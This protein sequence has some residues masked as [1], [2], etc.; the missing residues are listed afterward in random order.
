[1]VCMPLD[2]ASAIPLLP[3]LVLLLAVAVPGVLL[4]RSL[5][6]PSLAGFLV[7]GMLLGPYGFGGVAN[8]EQVSTLA[9]LGVVLLL[10][11]IGLE[12]SVP[13]L[14]AMRR[15]LTIGGLGQV[16]GTIAA[17]AAV[18]LAFGASWSFAL[19]VGFL[20]VTS[21]TAFVLR[22]LADTRQT[23]TRHGQISLGILLFQ[24]LCV[25]PIML[26]LPWVLGSR[27]AEGEGF[28]LA[29]IQA[30]GGVAVVLVFARYGF[31]RLA[32]LVVRVGGR[33][34]FV[35][36]IV[37]VALGA[38][39]AT[40]SMGLSLALGAFVAGLF[41]S[42]SEYSN[43]TVSEILPFRDVF[44]ALFFLSIGML[45]DT[46]TTLE[47]PEW[48][49]GGIG[50]L[51]VVKAGVLYPLM[52]WLTGST[53]V[54][55]LVAFGLFQA[56]EFSFVIAREA[57]K[58]GVLT[59]ADLQLFLNI[60]VLSLLLT[61]FVVQGLPRLVDAL[62][63]KSLRKD[64]E[65][66]LTD[67]ERPPQVVIVGYGPTGRHLARVLRATGVP[68]CVLEL[69][70][71]T[72]KSAAKHGIPILFGDANRPD[73]LE[74][75]G[76]PTA[77]VLVLAIPDQ[78]ATRRALNLARGM[79]PHI[80]IIVRTRFMSDVAELRRMGADQVVP[81]E[82]ETSVAIFIRVLERLGVPRGN[83]LVE[84]ELIRREGYQLLRGGDTSGDSLETLREV[85]AR[86][87]VDEVYVPADSPVCGRRLG[88]LDLQGRTGALVL[89]A[90]RDG[91][92]LRAPEA[93]LLL[94]GG[95]LL[96]LAGAHDALRDARALLEGRG[97]DTLKEP[98][99]APPLGSA[100][101]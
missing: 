61:P 13:K 43:Q 25:I 85:L 53:R 59:G 78:A 63:F 73:A 77:R 10:F 65:G 98:D 97:L 79:A 92:V 51:I 45:V 22:S 49:L 96:V 33:E 9:E 76:V 74:R 94:A 19:L 5:R 64:R 87:G 32:Q 75:L 50:L 55:L 3:D 81:E 90:L 34:L 71:Q 6:L 23:N 68:F 7:I 69:N 1:M 2:A 42:E 39:L 84:S 37:L 26:A 95:D 40:S 27:A 67:G 99:T 89:S 62:G 4:F 46:R 47:R 36:F 88:E 18:A 31:P 60:A 52:A 72:V 41:I 91:E 44:S 82:F 56:G 17:V 66:V 11:T 86:T 80:H 35:L 28:V 14:F 30:V 12:F 29:I 70:A 8:V 58:A 21:A 54:A 48:V 16:V 24:D 38:A 20:A 93:S 83:I 15:E 101:G 57:E 100:A